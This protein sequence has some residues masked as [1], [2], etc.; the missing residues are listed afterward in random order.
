MKVVEKALQIQKVVKNAGRLKEIISTMS[1]FGFKEFIYKLKLTK[2]LDDS[3]KTQNEEVK[4]HLPFRLRALFEELGP[5]FIKLGQVLAG[6]PDLIPEEFTL[7]FAKLQDKVKEVPF[8]DIKNTIEKELEKPLQNI[9]SSFDPLPLAT[10][11]I[12][13]VHK[14]RSLEGDD[15]VVKVVKPNVEKILTQDLEILEMFAGLSELYVEEIKMLQPKKIV[16]EFKRSLLVEIDLKKEAFQMKRFRDNFSNSSFIVIPESYESLSSESVLCMERLEG[17]KLQDKVALLKLG[18]DLKSFIQEGVKHHLEAIM[19]HGFFH[20][21][22]HGGNILAL[23]SGQMALLDF[24]STGYLSPKSKDSL[25]NMFLSL[26]SEDYD[27]LVSEYIDI[28]P[29]IG[30]KRNSKLIQ[31]IQREVSSLFGP[32]FGMPLKNI[33]ASELLMKGAAIALKY[34]ITLP[35]DLILV[36][37]SNMTLEGLGR[38]LDPDLDLLKN[39]SEFSQKILKKKYAPDKL[40][41]SSL[42][43]IRSLQ[44]LAQKSP[45]L[46]GEIFQQIENGELEINVLNKNDEKLTESFHIIAKN[47]SLAI[48]FL[49][50]TAGMIALQFLSSHHKFV[51]ITLLV[52][53][54]LIFLLLLKSIYFPKK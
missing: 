20:A 54:S 29:S 48:I 4:G 53:W 46:I 25:I 42:S 38:S 31:E 32:Y 7:E 43:N 17:V 50:L 18:I 52:A 49:S 23:P 14:A 24:G 12:A 40:L 6:R 13:Q 39:A 8:E 47:L 11:S 5:T 15:L 26:V 51:E 36:F 37:K 19:I 9:F 35:Q 45:R 2:F 34:N 1:R 21:D 28:S 3:P 27:A 44:K 30:V 33:P 10:A 16:E 41:K 22:P